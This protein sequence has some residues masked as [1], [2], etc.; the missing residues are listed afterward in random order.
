MTFAPSHS[1]DTF[2][3][4]KYGVFEAILI[5]H[6]QFW[7]NH[8]K[9]LDRN[10]Y[11]GNTWMYQTHKEIAAHFIYF[12]HKQV[13][14]I[15][16]SLIKQGVI[17]KGNYNKTKF[18]RTVWYSFV[19]EEIFALSRNRE[20]EISKSG[21]PTK[22]IGT[23]IPDTKTDAL[24]DKNPLP[25]KGELLVFGDFVKISKEDLEKLHV[26][27]GKD[28]ISNLIEEMNDYL[29]YSGKKPYK[30]YTAALRT[31]AKRRKA[32]PTVVKESYVEQVKKRFQNGGKYNEAVCA[33]DSQG[34]GFSRG[35]TQYQVLFKAAGFKEQ[36]EN[37]LRKFGIPVQDQKFSA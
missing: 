14:R 30:D 22:H 8:N 13:E 34:I 16:E 36:F 27:F 11:D 12:S 23:P 7:I 19:N 2:L 6:F 10:F 5:T 4:E 17:K 3:A 26:Q 31:W 32:N 28:L 18:D 29:S 24:T 33:W 25:P 15:I 20:M 1:F 21:N 35:M 9:K 37:I